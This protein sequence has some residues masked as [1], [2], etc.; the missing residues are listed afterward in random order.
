MFFEE[1][2]NS[3]KDDILS[4]PQ[5]GKFLDIVIF[6]DYQY[7]EEFE[8]YLIPI[9]ITKKGILGFKKMYLTYDRIKPKGFLIKKGTGYPENTFGLPTLIFV[10]YTSCNQSTYPS[11]SKLIEYLKTINDQ[12]PVIVKENSLPA[13]PGYKE[14]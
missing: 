5:L 1:E 12:I 3:W 10:G 6:G 7:N 13:P 11:I 14:S 4:K 2:L 9:E 8:T